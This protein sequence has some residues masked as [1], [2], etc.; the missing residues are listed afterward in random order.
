MGGW[1]LSEFPT[2]IPLRIP[3]FG[4]ANSGPRGWLSLAIPSWAHAEE[5]RSGAGNL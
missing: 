4:A 1:K 2:R 3:G 5:A